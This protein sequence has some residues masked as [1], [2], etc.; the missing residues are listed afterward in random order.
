MWRS[1]L[2]LK[3]LSE[4]VRKRCSEGC[5]ERWCSEGYSEGVRKVVRMYLY[6]R[7]ALSTVWFLEGQRTR[8][9]AHGPIAVAAT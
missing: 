2:Y 9:D 5:S 4:G 8:H 6:P 3:R 7:E 1:P